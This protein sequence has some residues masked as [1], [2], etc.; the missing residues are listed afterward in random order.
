M[1]VPDSDGAASPG[2]TSV[3]NTINVHVWFSQLS[4]IFRTKRI[5]SQNACFAYVVEKLPPNIAS[6]VSD[7]FD[8]IPTENPFDVL[9]EANCIKDRKVKFE[10]RINDLFNTLQLDQNKPTQLLRKMKNLL[11]NNTMSKTL[12]RKLWLDKLP[13][14]T[15]QI[16]ATLPEDL[17]L[18]RV[19]EIA[20]RIVEARTLNNIHIFSADSR[21]PLRYAKENVH[22]TGATE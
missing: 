4:A 14:H 15:A 22:A 7:L 3:F 5:Q 13:T 18:I 12:L 11:G 16:L 1:T 2:Q 17:D 10:R 19:A 6:V 8:N 21:P 20:D 9:K